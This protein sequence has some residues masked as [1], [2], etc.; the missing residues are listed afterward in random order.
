MMAW[1]S[2]ALGMATGQPLERASMVK[3]ERKDESSQAV[4]EKRERKASLKEWN[5]VWKKAKGH[6]DK[7]NQVD[8]G[9]G[10]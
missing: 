3:D 6:R 2:M 7:A 8:L 1:I 9:W 10:P 4:K 5:E